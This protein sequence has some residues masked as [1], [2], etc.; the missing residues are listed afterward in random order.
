LNVARQKIKDLE[1]LLREKVLELEN[2]W[3]RNILLTSDNARLNDNIRD[4][5]LKLS[6]AQM[7]FGK[8]NDEDVFTDD[9]RFFTSCK[10]CIQT[11]F[12]L[13]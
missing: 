9:V 2:V 4:I 5:S 6:T 10:S 11:G 7:L 3:D 1:N 8:D 13:N 12:S